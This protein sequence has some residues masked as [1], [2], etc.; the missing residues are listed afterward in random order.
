MRFVAA[1]AVIFS[2]AATPQSRGAVTSVTA[3]PGDGPG[4]FLFTVQGTRPCGA[5]NL[6]TGDGSSV[7]HAVLIPTTISYQFKRTGDFTV[8]ASG[9]GNCDG[10]ATTVVHVTSLA[11]APPSSRRG[12]VTNVTA[13]PDPA[14]VGLFLFTVTGTRPCGAVNLDTGDGSSSTHAV[15]IPTTIWYEYNRTGQFTVRAS[16]QGNC[17][18]VATTTV[19]VTAVRAQAPPPV[20]APP[21]SRGNPPA[22]PAPEPPQSRGAQPRGP[23]P[24]PAMRFAEMDRNH[25]GVIT[26]NEWNGDAQSFASHDWNGDGRLSGDEV[27]V[28]ATPPSRGRQGGGFNDW[29][30]GRFRQLDLNRDGQLSRADWRYDPDEFRRL[31]RNR[32]DRLSLSEFMVGSIDEDR[33]DRFD[34]LDAN[35]N[36]RIERWEWQSSPETF[37]W[38]DRNNDGVLSRAEVEAGNDNESPRG[39]YPN[40]GDRGNRGGSGRTITISVSSQ[41]AWTDTGITVRAGDPIQIRASGQIRFSGNSRDIAEPDGARGRPPTAAAPLP[42]VDI[43]ALVARIGNSAPFLVGS[44]SGDLRAPRDGRLYLGVNDDILRDN[45][46]QFRVVIT[47][48]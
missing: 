46:G 23:E 11:P 35:H 18:G 25:D 48:R 9:Q 6:D 10:T 12:A 21:P 16:G 19:R 30:E 7:T 37:R 42:H 8:R 41:E 15:L 38:L 14:N 1:T 36:N 43:G 17:D 4:T 44:D 3:E 32:D 5:V 22:T 27:R 39:G 13:E 2:L 24:Q 45:A 40:Y 31:D 28:G 26:R 20:N 34:D 47:V 33:G 29:T